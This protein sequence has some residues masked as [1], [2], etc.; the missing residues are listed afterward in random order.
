MPEVT[1]AEIEPRF[2]SIADRIAWATAVTVDRQ[3]RPRSRIL[4]PI[5]EGNV[6]FIAT[7][8][9]SHKEKH[10]AANPFMSITYWDPQHEQVCAECRTSW[11]D[12]PAEKERIWELYK[13]TPPPVGYDLAMIWQGGLEDPSYGLLRLEPWRL[14]VWSI[15]EMA[16]GQQETVWRPENG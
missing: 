5:W 14:S 1:F 6:G 11:E 3:G 12:D 16:Q 13:A 7:G 10:L 15:G 4:H 9:H 2:R 8:R